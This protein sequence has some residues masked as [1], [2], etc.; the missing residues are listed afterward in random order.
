MKLINYVLLST[1]F[2]LSACNMFKKEKA[3]EEVQSEQTEQV[4]A[5][6]SEGDNAA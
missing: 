5:A 4:T 1:V 6:P 2:A 3:N